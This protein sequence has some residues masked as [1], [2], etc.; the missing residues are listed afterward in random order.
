[1]TKQILNIRP[2]NK[3][4]DVLHFS[5]GVEGLNAIISD[6]GYFGAGTIIQII[7]PEK[8]GK[9]T[10]ALDLVAKNQHILPDVDIDQHTYNVGWV[11]FEH[12]FSATYAEMLGVDSSKI[13]IVEERYGEDA[14]VIVESLFEAGIKLI[15]VDSIPMFQAKSE[16]DKLLT[17]SE[18]VAAQAG[19]V[20]RIM[21][22]MVH[23]CAYY[24]ATMVLINQMRSNISTFSRKETKPAGAKIIQYISFL[25]IE[26]IRVN[27]ED[28][29]AKTAAVV[30]K[31]KFGAEGGKTEFYM[32]YGKGIDYHQHWIFL[33]EL[34]NIITKKGA[35]F[36]FTDKEGK[37]YKAQGINNTLTFPIEEIKELVRTKLYN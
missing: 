30:T 2:G 37:E 9:T 22:R 18:K 6:T 19:P 5:F 16:E 7:A 27:N 1:M 24:N 17:E 11:D 28:T 14:F 25:T 34:H 4:K 33:A 15:V 10:L 13:A 21:R 36:Y 3:P 32:L 12:Q 20:T 31:N 23:L 29:R 8:H 26:L 35:W